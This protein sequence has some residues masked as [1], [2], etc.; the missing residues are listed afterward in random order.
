MVETPAA[1][2]HARRLI[3]GAALDFVSIGTND[4]TQ[5]VMAA[6]RLHPALTDL[7]NPW[8]VA[9]LELIKDVCEAGKAAGANV[10]VCGEAGG[11][12]LL[13]LVLVGLGVDSLSMSAAKVP[14]V[15]AA[16]ARHTFAEC[17]ELA[18]IALA[19]DSA[20]EARAA[21]FA[22]IPETADLCG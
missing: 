17:Q 7:N 19:A 3:E 16:L 1:A 11:H 22:K 20:E 6:D 14:A 4:L 9:V 5:Y 12:P 15:R 10:G 2:I 13:A 18:Q 21:V 8:Q